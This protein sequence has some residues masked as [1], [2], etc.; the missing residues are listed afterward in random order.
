MTAGRVDQR[1]EPGALRNHE[2]RIAKLENSDGSWPW[3][4]VGTYPTDPFTTPDSPAFQNG[5]VNVGPP[6]HLVA[7]KRFLNWVKIRGAFTGGADGSIVF[8]LPDLYRPT[9]VVPP[10]PGQL[11][12]GSGIF[13]FIVDAAG[14]VTYITSGAL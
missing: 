9:M 7:F 1:S 2:D 6:Y 10:P 12:D 14:N 4:Y 5:W 11:G 13:N 8:T 3:I